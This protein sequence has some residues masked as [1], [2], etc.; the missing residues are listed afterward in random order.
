ME[1]A[2]GVFQAYVAGCVSGLMIGVFNAILSR[3]K[4]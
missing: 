2:E 1:L 3:R 4:S